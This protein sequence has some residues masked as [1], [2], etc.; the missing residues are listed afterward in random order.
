MHSSEIP[1]AFHLRLGR[2]TPASANLDFN[3]GLALNWLGPHNGVDVIKLLDPKKTQL[4]LRLEKLEE[5]VVKT[6]DQ[7]LPQVVIDFNAWFRRAEQLRALRNDYVHAR[8]GFPGELK[9]EE[10]FVYFLPLHWNM[11]PDQTDKTVK[12]TFSEFDRQIKEVAD[13]AGDFSRVCRRYAEHAAP[14]ISWLKQNSPAHS[15]ISVSK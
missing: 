1:D 4:R 2:L 5:L 12:L 14:A 3:V 13:L 8:W 7:D 15:Q 6:Y 9:Q 11:G 10:P